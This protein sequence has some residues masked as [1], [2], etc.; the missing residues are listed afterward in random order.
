MGSSRRASRG[1]FR[2][3]F[4]RSVGDRFSRLNVKKTGVGVSAGIPGLRKSWHSSGRST[5]S[6]GV[7]GTG[8]SWQK[9]ER[10][11]DDRPRPKVLPKPSP[12]AGWYPDPTGRLDDRCWDG[13]RW[14][15]QSGRGSNVVQDST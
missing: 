5:T 4:R 10:F 13:A 9:V 7:P 15:A 2:S 8:V 1:R 6:M 11:Q 12:P 14:T 3:R